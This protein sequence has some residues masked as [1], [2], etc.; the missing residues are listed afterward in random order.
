MKPPTHH[1]V[2]NRVLKLN[3]G[4]L[5]SGGPG[6]S[7]QTEFDVPAVRVADDLDL[8]F[9]KG[10]MR[11]SRTKEGILVQGQLEVG[12]EGE[13]SRCLD[14][15]LQ[16]LPIEIEELYSYPASPDIEFAVHEDGNLDLA[17]LLRAEI[18]IAGSRNLMC[19]EDCQGLCP[20]CGANRNR[21]ICTCNLDDI[22]PRLARLKELLDRD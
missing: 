11:L 22:D 8:T 18:M 10:P 14:P 9:I 19:R 20:D 17:P 1:Y 16:T 13:C 5:I 21:E 12:L 15:V 4:F 2:S 7:H 3:V 6:H